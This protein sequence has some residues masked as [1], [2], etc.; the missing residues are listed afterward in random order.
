MRSEVAIMLLAG[1]IGLGIF[2]LIINLS[3]K[4]KLKRLQE[5]YDERENKSRG[6]RTIKSSEL[7]VERV[8]EPIE[9]QLL[10]TSTIATIREDSNRIERN[11]G[12]F[13]PESNEPYDPREEK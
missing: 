4:R 13:Y 11:E 5:E 1:L 9:R 7:A 6:T 3:S 12:S 2:Y 10:P 8:R